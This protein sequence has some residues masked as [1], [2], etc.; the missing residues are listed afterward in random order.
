MSI[1]APLVTAIML[2]LILFVAACSIESS[3]EIA[4]EP[5]I[6]PTSDAPPA[7]SNLPP[8]TSDQ[9]PTPSPEPLPTA[10]FRDLGPAPEIT[11]EIWLNTDGALPLASLRG[12]VVLIEF[13]TF[14]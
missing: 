4:A 1:K 9:P 7:T 10:P 11:N 5:T 12:Q 8:A 13:W 6:A 14:G 2:A 3:P